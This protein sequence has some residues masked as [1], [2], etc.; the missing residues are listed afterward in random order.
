[1]CV[2][3][4]VCV[5]VLGRCLWVAIVENSIKSW[6]FFINQPAFASELSAMVLLFLLSPTKTLAFDGEEVQLG[7]SCKH[8]LP[9]KLESTSVLAKVMKAKSTNDIKSLMNLSTNLAS[10]NHTRCVLAGACASAQVLGPSLYAFFIVTS[11]YSH[12]GFFLG[13]GGLQS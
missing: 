3:V 12:C 11:L 4:C 10:L 6:P 7:E 13:G 5:C 2:C 1:M 9:L 8:T